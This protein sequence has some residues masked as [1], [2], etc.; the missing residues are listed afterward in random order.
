MTRSSTAAAPLKKRLAA[1]QPVRPTPREAAPATITSMANGATSRLAPSPTGAKIRKNSTPVTALTKAAARP[2]AKAPASQ[3]RRASPRR[4]SWWG[5]VA[6]PPRWPRPALLPALGQ[7]QA[8][9]KED[10]HDSIGHL[11]TGSEEIQRMEQE[12]EQGGGRE[13]CQAIVGPAQGLRRLAAA[14]QDE[15]PH[16][17]WAVARGADV[18]P[19]DGQNRAAGGQAGA[20]EQPEEGVDGDRHDVDVQAVD[21]EQMHGATAQE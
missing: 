2:T 16:R 14:D 17:R 3:R 13:R 1:S 21:G 10:G 18:Q 11:E 19:Q 15:G 4:E 20:T 5:A 12:C 6:A 9:S 7:R 8:E